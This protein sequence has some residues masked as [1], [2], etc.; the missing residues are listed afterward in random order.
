MKA[1]KLLT[2]PSIHR[3]LIPDETRKGDEKFAIF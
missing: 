3:L 1:L 2:E